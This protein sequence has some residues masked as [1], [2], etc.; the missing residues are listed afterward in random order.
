MF[1][2]K[3]TTRAAAEQRYGHIDFASK[4]WPERNHWIRS[5]IIPEGMFP[6]WKVLNTKIPVKT[7]ACNIDIHGPLMAALNSVHDKGLGGQLK[8]FDGCFNIRMVR[9]TRSAFSAHSYGL[10]VDLNAALN[11]MGKVLHTTFTPEFVKCFTDQGFAWGGNFKSRRDPMHFS[12][13]W[14]G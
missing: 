14:E 11:P 5:L 3:C 6:N 8:T 9:G 13:C 12:Y 4:H 1:K 2:N 10:A 7:I